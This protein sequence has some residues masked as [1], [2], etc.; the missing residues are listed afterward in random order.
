MLEKKMWAKNGLGPTA[1]RMGPFFPATFLQIER[2]DCD[3]CSMFVLC[4]VKPSPNHPHHGCQISNIICSYVLILDVTF[5]IM[6]LCYHHHCLRNVWTSTLSERRE[7]RKFTLLVKMAIRPC[8][9]PAPI[10]SRSA[11]PSLGLLAAPCTWKSFSL[12]FTWS[13]WLVFCPKLSLSVFLLFF[14][15]FLLTATILFSSDASPLQR[16]HLFF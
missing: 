10:L 14:F 2:T 3:L 13:G 6:I 12:V 7:T 5:W 4:S 11:R 16:I 15:N 1:Y 8:A 9:I